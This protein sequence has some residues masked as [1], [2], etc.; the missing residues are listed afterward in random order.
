MAKAN[1]Q[2]VSAPP[3]TIGASNPEPPLTPS[4][5]TRPSE[6]GTPRDPSSLPGTPL[7]SRVL[8]SF[9]GTPLFPAFPLLNT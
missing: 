4:A 1:W 3:L 6:G 8:R 5:A 7:F 9:P 2:K